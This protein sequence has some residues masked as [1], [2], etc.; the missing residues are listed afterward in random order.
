M[1]SKCETVEITGKLSRGQTAM[2]ELLCQGAVTIEKLY[3]VS[4]ANPKQIPVREMQQILGPKL[5]R[6]NNKVIEAGYKI[7][8]GEA[9]RTYEIIKI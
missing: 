5:T 7:V 9:R 8:P 4:V 2:W 3:S 6:L 1:T